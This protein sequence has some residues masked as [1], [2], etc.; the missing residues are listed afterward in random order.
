MRETYTGL[1]AR[2]KVQGRSEIDAMLQANDEMEKMG[3]Y[4]KT[5]KLKAIKIDRPRQNIQVFLITND[6]FRFG[7]FQD[8]EK[9][10]SNPGSEVHFSGSYVMH[11]DFDT[12]KKLNEFL[13][14]GNKAFIVKTGTGMY[15][16]SVQ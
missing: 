12:S 7:M 3:Y 8:I 10:I 15:L 2:F 16:M 6:E 5:R 4:P 9:A 1:V 11:Q 13:A 14:A